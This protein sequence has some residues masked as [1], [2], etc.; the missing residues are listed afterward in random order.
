MRKITPMHVALSSLLSFDLTWPLLV[1][2]QFASKA[3]GGPWAFVH[4]KNS[5]LICNRKYQQGKVTTLDYFLLERL[6]KLAAWPREKVISASRY[7]RAGVV[8]S[9]SGQAVCKTDRI[10]TV[11]QR[12]KCRRMFQKAM[13]TTWTSFAKNI[14]NSQLKWGWLISPEG[15]MQLTYQ[16]HTDE[17]NSYNMCNSHIQTKEL[18]ITY[19]SL[20]YRRKG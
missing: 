19:V 8:R 18:I 4:V 9:N 2:C 13:A 11:L 3:A 6:P 12:C 14:T 7:K 20:I 1:L 16:P 17:K 10:L 5:S 15:G